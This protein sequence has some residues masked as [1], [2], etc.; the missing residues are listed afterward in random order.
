MF[1]KNQIQR[2]EYTEYQHN[3]EVQFIP[4]YCSDKC[5][6]VFPAAEVKV[7]LNL[8]IGQLM[9]LSNKSTVLSAC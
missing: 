9:Q 3:D 6:Y 7:K 4:E 8:T 2:I 1:G 5:K